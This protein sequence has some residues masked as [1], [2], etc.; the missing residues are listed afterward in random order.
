MPTYISRPDNTQ[1]VVLAGG[2][3]S[4]AGNL[5]VRNNLGDNSD[6][7]FVTRT[8]T[9]PITWAFALTAPSIPSDEFVCRIGTSIR[10]KGGGDARTVGGATYLS[11]DP[12]PTTFS[13]VVTGG[14]AT[15]VT[16]QLGVAT[17]T[18][19]I[20]QT[21]NMRYAWQDN[22]Y[23]AF[24]SITYELFSTVYTLKRSTALPTAT[25]MTNNATPIVPVQVTNTIDWEAGT[26]DN[27]KLRKITVELRIEANSSTGPETTA[28]LAT[29][30]LDYYALATGTDTVS[31]TTSNSLPNTTYKM[32]ARA[33]RHREGETSVATEQIGAWSAAVT[34]TM[35]TLLPGLPAGFAATVNANLSTVTL[36][37]TAF[38]T[39][40]YTNPIYIEFQRS[41][42]G[43]TTWATI[44]NGRVLTPP[45]TLVTITDYEAPRGILV[46]YRSRVLATFT[47]GF[48][49]EGNWTTASVTATVSADNWNLKV[50]QQDTLNVYNLRVL[51]D[52]MEDITED[53]GV[54]RPLD[55]RY[56]VVIA[57]KLGGWDGEFTIAT[58]TTAEWDAVK[59][60]VEAQRVLL[61]QSPFGWE[62]YIRIINGAR[63]L[64]QGTSTSPRRQVTFQYVEVDSP[65]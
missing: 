23:T 6:A 15:I 65:T 18:W 1:G 55:R 3:T 19:S 54:F 58:I 27:Q 21:A 16:Y 56:P 39:G 32:Y 31:V 38:T 53:L 22:T 45:S 52:P 59:A 49:N 40:S 57:G 61:L 35:S 64:I 46:Y 11:T 34:L 9:T 10:V 50:P 48:L 37:A 30:T 33:I 41:D 12:L 47:G 43:G 63:T 25:T 28:A 20:A 26:N 17:K 36:S 62:K 4:P 44:R 8:T 51:T 2:G 42:D 14:G 5:N 60:L 13:T 29:G 7:T 24:T